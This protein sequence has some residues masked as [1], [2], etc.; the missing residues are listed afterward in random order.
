LA[1]KMT[2]DLPTQKDVFL[3]HDT[4]G[5]A[6]TFQGLPIEV[7]MQE[8]AG[9]SDEEELVLFKQVVLGVLAK[10]DA[11]VQL[12]A[13]RFFDEFLKKWNQ[14]DPISREEFVSRLTPASIAIEPDGRASLEFADDHD[15]FWG[16][17]LI[18]SFDPHS[19]ITDLEL[20]G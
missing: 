8:A 11:A 3:A 4:W 17:A 10:K 16:H 1:G 12:A 2:F 14:D 18:V 7:S 19:N 13:D 9:L 6:L 5:F 20:A 15:M